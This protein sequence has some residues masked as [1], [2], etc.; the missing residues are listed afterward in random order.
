M[1]IDIFWPKISIFMLPWLPSF[2]K[3]SKWQWNVVG[4]LCQGVC[5]ITK[6][7]LH[8]SRNKVKKMKFEILTS[9]S[10]YRWSTDSPFW[11]IFMPKKAHTSANTLFSA[12]KIGGGA[13][14][15]GS[16]IL[17]P[18]KKNSII[19]PFFSYCVTLI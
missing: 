13:Q 4:L 3:C 2:K 16:N 19:L 11:V 7:L 18:F 14:N 15:I 6:R 10:F 5:K 12:E 8:F 9:I 1:K 17:K